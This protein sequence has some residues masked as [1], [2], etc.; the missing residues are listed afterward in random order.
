MY[1]HQLSNSLSLSDLKSHIVSLTHEVGEM[2]LGAVH[3]TLMWLGQAL[4]CGS[5]SGSSRVSPSLGH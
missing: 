5:D 3:F 2:A 4:R 1:I